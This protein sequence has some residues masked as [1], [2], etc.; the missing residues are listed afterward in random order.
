MISLKGKKS[1]WLH[2]GHVIS[3]VGV[4]VDPSK[5]EAVVDWQHPTTVH[6]VKSFL[7][8]VKYY[9]R[10]IEGFSK[11]PSQLTAWPRRKL[12]FQER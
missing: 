8:L 10:F 7:G 5:I 12:S 3:S 2:V 6:E 1:S 4:T 9:K 11:L